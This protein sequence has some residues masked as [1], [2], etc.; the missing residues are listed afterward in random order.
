MTLD[1]ALQAD[2][3]E[4]MRGRDAEP[5]LGILT[6]IDKIPD[7]DKRQARKVTGCEMQIGEDDCMESESVFERF[8]RIERAMGCIGIGMKGHMGRS[9]HF[10]HRSHRI[11]AAYF[12]LLVTPGGLTCAFPA[13]SCPDFIPYSH[14]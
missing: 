10:I 14:L 4:D 1:V 13:D 2:A 3:N 11:Y 12:E 6:A 7:R 9:D 8:E 5:E